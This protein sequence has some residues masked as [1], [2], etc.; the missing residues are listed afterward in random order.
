MAAS[1]ACHHSRTENDGPDAAPE[2][3]GSAIGVAECDDYLS[4]YQRCVAAHVPADQKKA[5]EQSL[6]RT[7]ASWKALAANPGARPGLPQ[8]CH[9]ALETVQ[10]T[11]QS[12]ACA[13]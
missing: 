3:A 12:Y 8:A 10:T 9:L 2:S 11:M 4:K 5:F 1:V 6:E 7:R 13:W